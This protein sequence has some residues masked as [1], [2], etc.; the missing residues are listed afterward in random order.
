[1]FTQCLKVCVIIF[2]TKL[3]A[4]KTFNKD[5]TIIFEIQI[6]FP[7]VK[8]YEI[9]DLN[10]I[11]R[12]LWQNSKDSCNYQPSEHIGLAAHYIAMGCKVLT[13]LIGLCSEYL[14]HTMRSPHC[15][16]LSPFSIPVQSSP[17]SPSLVRNSCMASKFHMRI[18]KLNI[19]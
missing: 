2:T 1:M 13:I 16:P 18:I 11:V 19:L 12:F 7:N 3:F 17:C 6:T 8:H 14:L 15:K 4:S 10:D 5:I 9:I